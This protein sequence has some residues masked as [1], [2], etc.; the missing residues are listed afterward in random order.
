MAIA[1][2]LPNPKLLAVALVLLAPVAHAADPTEGAKV[3]D[4]ECSDCHSVKP[5]KNKKGPSLFA[6]IGRPAGSIA[7]FNYSNAMKASG[8]T[9][10]ADRFNDY[11]QTPKKSVPGGKMKFDGLAS[12]ASRSDLIAFLNS[13]H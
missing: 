10:T 3:F 6:V 7:D 2:S 11:I 1:I 13:L 5:G 4:E 12:A 9:W 8:I